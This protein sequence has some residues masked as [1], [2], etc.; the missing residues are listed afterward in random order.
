MV[1]C[2]CLLFVFTMVFHIDCSL[3]VLC[4]K[5]VKIENLGHL[6][7]LR[8]LNLA[9][10]EIV[11]VSNVSGMR[12]LSELNLRRNKICTVVCTCYLHILVTRLHEWKNSCFTT[13]GF[14]VFCMVFSSELRSVRLIMFPSNEWKHFA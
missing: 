13:R 7:E 6:N 8:V 14:F 2:M 12:A 1:I 10:N 3:F 11:H 5:I 4:F 9:G